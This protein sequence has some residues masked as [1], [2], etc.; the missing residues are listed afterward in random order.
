M[1]EDHLFWRGW[2]RR[3]ARLCHVQV[4]DSLQFCF[5]SAL[6]IF[7]FG[8]LAVDFCNV[9]LEPGQSADAGPPVGEVVDVRDDEEQS[10]LQHAEGEL[11]L[12]EASVLDLAPQVCG[13]HDQVREE[14][15]C[16]AVGSAQH[17]DDDLPLNEVVVV[18]HHAAHATL[19]LLLLRVFSRVEGD[20]LCIVSDVDKPISKVSFVP[21]LIVVD[22]HELMA[23]HDQDDSGGPRVDKE[24]KGQLP[25]DLPENCDV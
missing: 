7:A 1:P 20:C 25:A 23:G 8:P 5:S 12:D 10:T 4:D 2:R 11:S 24:C 18:L 19:G 13:S 6:C 22:A 16:I 17:A 9:R 21:Q 15:A 14:I 3:E